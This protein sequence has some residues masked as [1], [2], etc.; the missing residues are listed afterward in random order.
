MQLRKAWTPLRDKPWLR[1]GQTQKN[2]SRSWRYVCVL[3]RDYK[4]DY[5][6]VRGCCRIL[7]VVLADARVHPFFLSRAHTL[8]HKFTFTAIFLGRF[9]QLRRQRVLQQP[10]DWEGAREHRP[11][12]VAHYASR[13]GISEGRPPV[14]DCLNMLA[15][16]ALVYDS[17]DWRK[18]VVE[19]KLSEATARAGVGHLPR[20]VDTS[21]YHRGLYSLCCSWRDPAAA[22]NCNPA[23]NFAVVLVWWWRW[24]WRWR[25]QRQ[26]HLDQCPVLLIR[27]V[28]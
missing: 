18:A 12:D 15:F 21:A 9:Q 8:S 19:P 6:H 16:F 7:A 25:S 17:E 24:R 28:G 3:L 23:P 20:H 4:R 2:T 10:S 11:S 14:R 1:P 5:T 13:Y 27:E 22:S 26:L